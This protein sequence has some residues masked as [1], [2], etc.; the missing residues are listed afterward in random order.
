MASAFSDVPAFPSI[1]LKLNAA[2]T[3]QVNTTE[4]NTGDELHAAVLET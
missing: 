2:L 4:L 1:A 3:S